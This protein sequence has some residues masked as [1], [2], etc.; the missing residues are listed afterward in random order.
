MAAVITRSA[1]VF[2]GKDPAPDVSSLVIDHRGRHVVTWAEVMAARRERQERQLAWKRQAREV[3][4][5]KLWVAYFD[6][7]FF[8]GWHGFLENRDGRHWLR[9]PGGPR[10]ALMRL[11]PLVLPYGR[12]DERTRWERWMEA[13]ARAYRR[14]TQCRRPLGVAY[15]WSEDGTRGPFRLPRQAGEKTDPPSL[16]LKVATSAGATHVGRA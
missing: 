15:V 4:A 16:S 2:W 3:R 8:G 6:Q 14:R 13:F 9:Y 11:F 12:E 7:V 1:L 5:Y 10:N